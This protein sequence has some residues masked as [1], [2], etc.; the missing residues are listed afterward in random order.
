MDDFLEDGEI[1]E[2]SVDNSS[3]STRYFYDE[4]TGVTWDSWTAT[5]FVF[6]ALNASWV[7]VSGYGAVDNIEPAS[8]ATIRFV[9]KAS[10]APGISSAAVLL[11]DAVGVSLGRDRDGSNNTKRVRLKELLVSKDH[12]AVFF[13]DNEE[14]EKS[15]KEE[16][17]GF[18]VVDLGSTHGTY[19]N[20]KRL[21][22]AKNAS[23]P[24]RLKHGDTLQIG[25]TTLEV[26]LHPPPWSSCEECKATS[27]KTIVPDGEPSKANNTTATNNYSSEDR[28]ETLERQRK[29]EQKA[30]KARL[31]GDSRTQPPSSS[32]PPGFIDRSKLRRELHGPD[33][34]RP[35]STDTD[36]YYQTQQQPSVS[37][38]TPVS[39]KGAAMLSK[40]GYSG[41]GL[42]KQGQGIAEPVSAEG[43]RGGV[44]LGF[45]TSS[46]VVGNGNG[47]VSDWRQEGWRKTRERY[48][49]LE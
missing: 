36:S 7:P 29:E 45:G 11:V 16:G 41:G 4:K 40:L 5:G 21:S 26:H 30:L 9:V 31:V 49:S 19:F 28:K 15:E 32:R 42:G 13:K 17:P 35:F 48:E 38:T 34:T 6:D 27:D 18:F 37:T 25:S 14:L 22:A 8:D 44:G 2:S 24:A 43:T 47:N 1:A 46:G 20:G 39:G 10:N 12:A 23:K 3:N 33:R